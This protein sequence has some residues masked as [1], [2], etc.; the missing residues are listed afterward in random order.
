MNPNDFQFISYV[1]T[2]NDQFMLGIAKVKAYGK[3]EL[4]FKHVKTKDGTGTFFCCA[5]YTTQDAAN[6]KKYI[7]CFQIDSRSDEEMLY[8]I[9]R[10]GV[11]KLAAQRSAMPNQV[12][13]SQANYYPHGMAQQ[14]QAQATSMSEVATKQEELPF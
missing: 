7:A 13:P 2:P 9:I 12:Q 3:I 1:P 11:A 5:N 14:S 8:E 4:R 10:Q 6:E